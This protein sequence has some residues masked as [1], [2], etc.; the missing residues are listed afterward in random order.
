MQNLSVGLV[1]ANISLSNPRKPELTSLEVKSLVDT[2]AVML[3]IPEHMANQLSL[4]QNGTRH[5][6]TA[7]GR[8]HKVP[9]VGPVK[10][11]FGERLCFVGALVIGNEP[12]LGAVPMEDMDLIVHPLSRTVTVN[13]ESPNFPHHIIK[14]SVAN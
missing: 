3:C 7:D 8:S 1:Y 9:Y 6:S 4:E 13:P 14:S 5:V 12:L 10:I 2:G 11:T